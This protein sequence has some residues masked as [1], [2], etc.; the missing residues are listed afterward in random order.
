[1]Y[2]GVKHLLLYR[3]IMLFRMSLALQSQFFSLSC[4]RLL[5]QKWGYRPRP[6]PQV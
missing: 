5:R 2:I 1:M 3:S 6:R 4:A